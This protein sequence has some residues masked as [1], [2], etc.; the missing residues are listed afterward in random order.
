[1][2]ERTRSRHAV[3]VDVDGIIIIFFF[4]IKLFK[5]QK[6]LEHSKVDQHFFLEKKPFDLGR[7]SRVQVHLSPPIKSMP[8]K[9]AVCTE[10][11]DTLNGFGLGRPTYAEHLY[12][13]FRLL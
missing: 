3:S 5:C 7:V 6:Y 2:K 1:M 10:F 4:L 11:R 13:I 8:W 9:I 12:N